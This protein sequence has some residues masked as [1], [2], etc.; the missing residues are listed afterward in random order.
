MGI[1]YFLLSKSEID[2]VADLLNQIPE[3][4]GEFSVEMILNR[5]ANVESIII[6]AEYAGKIIGCKVA[7]NRYFDGSVYSWLGA[8]LP[9]FRN[10]GVA[11]GFLNKL[12]EQ[13]RMKFFRSI[14]FKT[15]NKHVNMLRFALKNGFSII[16]FEAKEPEFESRIELLKVIEDGKE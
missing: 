11:L 13:A 3:F 14:R 9:P 1:K 12:E 4:D 10:Q 7:Y 8:V 5:L 15:R 6:V 2:V 16:G